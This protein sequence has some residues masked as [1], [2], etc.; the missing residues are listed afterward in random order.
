MATEAFLA[1]GTVVSFSTDLVTPSYT[2]IPKITSV[3]AIGDTVEAKDKT[4]LEDTRRVYGTALKDSPDQSIVGQFLSTDTDQKAF[5]DACK[6]NTPIMLK[7]V[8]PDG[9]EASFE[10]LPLSFQLD[11]VTAEDWQTFTVTGRRNTDVVWVDAT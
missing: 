8:W 1:A 10:F 9:T 2:A 3:G 7:I 4:A 5:V 11:E 6:A